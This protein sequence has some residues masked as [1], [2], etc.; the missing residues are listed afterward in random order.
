MT[1][2]LIEVV[3][4]LARL[5]PGSLEVGAYPPPKT[6]KTRLGSKAHL[7]SNSWPSLTGDV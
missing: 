1:R 4:I 6:A 5:W 2:L 3:V 7:S